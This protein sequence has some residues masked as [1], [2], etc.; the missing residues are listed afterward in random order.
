MPISN[1]SPC[2][3][4]SPLPE[5]NR[6]PLPYHGSALPTELRGRGLLRKPSAVGILPTATGRLRRHATSFTL[7]KSSTCCSAS[8][9]QFSCSI[10]ITDTPYRFVPGEGFEPP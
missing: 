1:G 10:V 8:L 5:L 3:P 2:E 4:Q 7:E 9:C 6:R